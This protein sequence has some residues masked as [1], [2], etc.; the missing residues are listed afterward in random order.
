MKTH[1]YIGHEFTDKNTKIEHRISPKG[2]HYTVRL[3]RTCRSQA[4]LRCRAVKLNKA[5]K[6]L[7][8]VS[9]HSLWQM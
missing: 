6:M 2:R 3:C 4:V 7:I 1:C 8:E 5:R 9:E